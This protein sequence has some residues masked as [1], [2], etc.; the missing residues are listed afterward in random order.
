[1][2]VWQIWGQIIVINSNFLVACFNARSISIQ[3]NALRKITSTYT[4]LFIF[5]QSQLNSENVTEAHVIF[6]TTHLYTNVSLFYQSALSE[7]NF[8]IHVLVVDKQDLT[9]YH[10]TT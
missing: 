10:I 8:K 3:V 5:Y 9:D 7:Y 2:V 6:C 1:M 4:Q